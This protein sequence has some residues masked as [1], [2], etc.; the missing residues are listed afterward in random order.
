MSRRAARADARPRRPVADILIDGAPASADDLTYLAL[1]NY[2]A[3]TSFAVEDGAV[4]GLDLHLD[5]LGRSAEALFGEAPNESELRRLM[6]RA[7][8]GRTAAWL[9][10]S[11]FSPEVW[12][13]SPSWIGRPRVMTMTAGPVAPLAASLRLTVQPYER[14]AAE[15]KHLATF[16]LIRA[17][18]LARAA[19]FDDA[20]FVDAQGRLSE[21]SLWNIGFLSGEH[22]VWPRASMLGG[23]AQ[24]L[25]E[26]G[27]GANGLA[28][29]T[30]EIAVRDLAAFEA[31]FICNSA[32]PMCPVAAIDGAVFA[33][34]H[35]VLNRVRAC[36]A[37]QGPQPI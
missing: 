18:R 36:W 22:I 15:L 3:Y 33:V 29:E 34:D 25:I 27:A 19:G 16:G 24:G 28:C 2:G 17:R 37:A 26:R 6:R 7:V 23:V 8:E 4:R 10:V 32:T 13:R 20:L 35:P 31:A 1:V 11:L 14:E 12:P 5:R 21:G 30:R 9:R